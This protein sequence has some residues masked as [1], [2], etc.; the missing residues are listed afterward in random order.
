[1]PTRI[2]TFMIASTAAQTFYAA[3][4]GAAAAMVCLCAD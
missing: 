3:A 4:A 1:L 2:D